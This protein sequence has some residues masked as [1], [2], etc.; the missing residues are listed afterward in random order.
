MDGL[1]SWVNQTAG[2][3]Y[4]LGGLLFITGQDEEHHAWQSHGLDGLF[5]LVLEFVFDCGGAGKFEVSLYFLIA[6]CDGLF[7]LLADDGSGVHEL[8]VPAVVLVIGEGF[9]A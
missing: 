3:A 6:S 5:N 7:F 8:L 2:S 1:H 4:S 9:F